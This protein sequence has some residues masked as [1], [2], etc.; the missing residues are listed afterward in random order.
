MDHGRSIEPAIHHGSMVKE[1]LLPIIMI[2]PK[3]SRQHGMGT[4]N[5]GQLSIR[6]YLNGMQC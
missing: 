6:V 4:Q 1:R 2:G 5:V 3:V